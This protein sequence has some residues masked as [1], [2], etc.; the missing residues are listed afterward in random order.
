MQSLP[1]PAAALFRFLDDERVDYCVLGA[2]TAERIAIVVASNVLERVPA[3]LRSFGARNDLQLID[4]REAPDS[5]DIYRLSCTSREER[6]Q[7]LTIEVRVD[8][9]RC[10]H[11]IFTA[12]E[13]LR[14]RVRASGFPA[15]APAQAFVCQLLCCIDAGTISDSDGALLSSHWRRD[16]QG[17]EKRV[18]RFWRADREGGVI[19]RAAASGNW[20]G[21]HACLRPL[22]SA[23]HFR[24]IVPPLVWV[25]KA[26]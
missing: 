8:Y 15:L 14:E 21:V 12:S 25:R 23:L 5:V 17:V 26:C 1:A 13:L 19:M 24:N 10:G 6:P 20:E 16:P 4:R 22:Q 2:V 9:M 18:T 3:L 11:V 7:F